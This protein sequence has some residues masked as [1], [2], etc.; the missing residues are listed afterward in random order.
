MPTRV[1][2]FVRRSGP[3]VDEEPPTDAGQLP[4]ASNLTGWRKAI[5]EHAIAPLG[6]VV[7]GLLGMEGADGKSNANAAGHLL[8]LIA[9]IGG[10]P[11][12][13]NA[14]ALRELL[15]RE[16]LTDA[17]PMVN[18]LGKPVSEMLGTVLK[19]PVKSGMPQRLTLTG[20]K[21]PTGEM[22]FASNTKR[23]AGMKF[24]ATPQQV[25]ELINGG[26]L[27]LEQPPNGSMEAIRARLR[28]ALD[29]PDARD[30]Q[31]RRYTGNP[32]N[33]PRPGDKP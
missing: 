5:D 15:V 11:N 9:G 18:A 1:L 20:W 17:E 19:T 2:P 6:D 12:G 22:E 4:T 8:P 23:A 16:G 27:D 21:A 13:L 10:L 25:D 33:Y 30:A 24:N 7:R 26:A 31:F 28:K 14:A 3:P 29:T 32:R